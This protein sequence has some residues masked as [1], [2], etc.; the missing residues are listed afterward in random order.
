MQFVVTTAGIQAAAD[1]ELGGYKLVVPSFRVGSSYGY[2]PSVDDENLHGALLY[3]GSTS[4]F[5][6]DGDGQIHYTCWMDDT[7]G[8]FAYGEVGLFLADGTL[9]ALG[10]HE[11]PQ[12]KANSTTNTRGNVVSIDTIIEIANGQAVIEA[13]INEIAEA[14]F[15]RL[16]AV[17]QLLP[18]LT[19]P[20]NAYLIDETDDYGN[21]ILAY[22]ADD[23]AWSFSTHGGRILADG[24]AATLS[25]TTVTS[26]QIGD[27]PGDPGTPPRGRYIVLFTS[28]NFAGEARVVTTLDRDTDTIGWDEPFVGSGA[29]GDQFVVLQSSMSYYAGQ[30]GGLPPHSHAMSDVQGLAA[31]LA[32]KAPSTH[33]HTIAQV[34]GLQAAL[35][36]LAQG[37]I[38]AYFPA[39]GKDGNNYAYIDLP[40]FKIR[41]G[42]WMHPSN[43]TGANSTG[44]GEGL[45]PSIQFRDPDGT[46]LRPF[47]SVCMGVFC[48]AINRQNS[49]FWDNDVQAYSWDVNGFTPQFN[50]AKS[51]DAR[52]MGFFWI[53]IGN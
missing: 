35:D 52:I 17:A 15:L 14:K 11:S 33:A 49:R 3:T 40:G 6:V 10:T 12:A 7:V 21:A 9:F 16:A 41:M 46:T 13:V 2:T 24:V 48:Q 27:L 37:T 25:S 51:D 22:R 1:A 39:A 45:G 20:S 8:P 23:T 36:A 28:G 32:G 29:A 44:Y 31:A 4:N 26:N 19:S 53:A 5:Y 42:R 34:S 18:P 30:V 50:A 43:P 38:N 47:A